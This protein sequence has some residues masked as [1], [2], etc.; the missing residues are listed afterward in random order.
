MA[1]EI[2]I[3]GNLKELYKDIYTPET[4]SALSFLSHFNND[5]KTLMNAR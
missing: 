4:L 2:T 1:S 5:V 3:R